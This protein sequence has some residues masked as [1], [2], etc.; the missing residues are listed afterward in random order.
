[1]VRVHFHNLLRLQARLVLGLLLASSLTLQ[2]SPFTEAPPAA[3][4]SFT[5][6]A[7]LQTLTGRL[8][9]RLD[10]INQPAF[11]SHQPAAAVQESG[12]ILVWMGFALVLFRWLEPAF[13]PPRLRP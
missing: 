11:E 7:G 12:G 9:L 2:G 1:M 6:G 4:H 8:P 10:W 5:G 3:S 13:R